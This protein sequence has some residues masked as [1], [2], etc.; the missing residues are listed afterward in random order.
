MLQYLDPDA[1]DRAQVDVFA[2]DEKPEGA[3]RARV[4]AFEEAAVQQCN[5][6]GGVFF[7]QGVGEGWGRG[8]VVGGEDGVVA[9][10]VAAAAGLGVDVGEVGGG[11]GGR[12]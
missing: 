5:Q 8:E 6:D 1:P 11:G 9:L 12:G 7:A 2:A 4:V 10:G 3:L